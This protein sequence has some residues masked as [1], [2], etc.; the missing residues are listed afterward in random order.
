MHI[1]LEDVDLFSSDL[2]RPE[3][4]MVA[5]DGTVWAA[6]KAGACTRIAP[7]GQGEQVG[8][9]GGEPNGICLDR[10]NNVIVANIGGGCVQRLFAD[11]RHETIADSAAGRA[12]TTPNFPLLD[13]HDRLWVTNST[14]RATY[15]DALESPAADGWLTLIAGGSA[16]IVADGLSF[17]NGIALDAREEYVYVAE[18]YGRRVLRY[19]IQ[20]NDQL[21]PAESY[22]PYLGDEGYPDGIAFDERG[23][24]W[25]TLPMMNAVGVID[26]SGSW[27][28]V[29]V[30][31][32]GEK[33]RR[34]TNICFGGDDRR[35]AYIGSL[36][37]TSL[38]RLRVPWPGLRLVH[39]A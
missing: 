16:S 3:G 8:G 15:K 36:A 9:L 37:G 4:V 32:S 14:A 10:Q 1:R 27:S 28:I 11:G 22:G 18:T 34:P 12:M 5:R 33:L 39:Q 29:L 7:D 30:D 31:P 20:G 23:N 19:R 21:S 17:A 24:L 6:H 26:A 25:V 2:S 38:P 35:T 13:F